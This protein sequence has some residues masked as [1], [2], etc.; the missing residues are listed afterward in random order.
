MEDRWVWGL[1]EKQMREDKHRLGS[2]CPW[3]T[4]S[5]SYFLRCDLNKTSTYVC[6]EDAVRTEFV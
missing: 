3:V 1:S 5:P 4:S 2:C 6:G